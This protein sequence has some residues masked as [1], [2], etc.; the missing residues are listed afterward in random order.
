MFKVIH[1]TNDNSLVFS[2]VFHVKER[3]L[4]C[5]E[6]RL[7]Y[8]EKRNRVNKTNKETHIE[9]VQTFSD[10]KEVRTAYYFSLGT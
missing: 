2:K 1:K 3:A 7:A 4:A 9:V 6:K 8:A 5:A 10:A